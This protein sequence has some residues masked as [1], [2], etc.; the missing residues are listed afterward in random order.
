MGM[1]LLGVR[2]YDRT[3]YPE[4][5]EAVDKFCDQDGSALC[6]LFC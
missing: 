4:W 3:K 1:E 6:L 2:G 5:V